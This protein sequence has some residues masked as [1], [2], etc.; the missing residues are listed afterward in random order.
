MVNNELFLI[1]I[2]C[3]LYGGQSASLLWAK[4]GGGPLTN[5]ES[6]L[7]MNTVQKHFLK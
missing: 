3:A 6:L 2:K 5:A 4:G 7:A 1:V